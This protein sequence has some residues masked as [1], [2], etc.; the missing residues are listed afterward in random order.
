[1]KFD[2]AKDEKLL[3]GFHETNKENRGLKLALG[4]FKCHDLSLGLTT[5][6]NAWKHVSREC[7]RGITF[8]LLGM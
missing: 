4:V 1:V 2:G 7:N 8:A 6:G 3:I 5:K